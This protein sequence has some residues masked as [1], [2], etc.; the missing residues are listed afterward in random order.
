MTTKSFADRYIRQR[1]IVPQEELSIMA[2][3]VVGCGAIGSQVAKQL[4]H[5]GCGKIGLCDFDTVGPENLACQGFHEKHL[6]LSKV[7]AIH[8]ELKNINSEIKI[9]PHADKFKVSITPEYNCI[10]SCVDDMDIRKFIFE[11]TSHVRFLVDGRMKG[12]EIIRVVT[13]F[14]EESRQYYPNS[15]FAQS[16]AV[17]GSCTSKTTVYGAYVAAGIMVS[18]FALWVARFPYLKSDILMD[19]G[20]LT[21]DDLAQKVTA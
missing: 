20:M 4:A 18:Q 8:E 7:E 19:L 12:G 17:Q 13:I 9:V 1:D 15:L 14:D 11:R 16:E 21:I 6:G 3:L 2:A 10:F 5:I